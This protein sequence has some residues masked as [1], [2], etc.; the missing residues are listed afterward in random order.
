M[1]GQPANCLLESKKRARLSTHNGVT[2]KGVT[3][4]L[5][6]TS[7]NKSIIA[8]LAQEVDEIEKLVY[9]L[10]RSLQGA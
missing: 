1:E 6:L 10:S 8:L 5:Y 2:R 4:T 9:Y 7:T 3:L